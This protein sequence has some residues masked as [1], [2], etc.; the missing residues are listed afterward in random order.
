MLILLLGEMYVLRRFGSYSGLYEFGKAI[1]GAECVESL[2][3]TVEI[4]AVDDFVHT[5]RQRE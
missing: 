1:S 3:G 4:T 2:S 5:K